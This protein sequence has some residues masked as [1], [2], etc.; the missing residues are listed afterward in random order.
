MTSSRREIDF[1]ESNFVLYELADGGMEIHVMA[2][3]SAAYYF[4]EHRLDAGEIVRYR[5]RGRAALMV[6]ANRVR[7]QG[8]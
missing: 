1:D 6:L 2:N 7:R 8:K 5:S 4:I 3:Q